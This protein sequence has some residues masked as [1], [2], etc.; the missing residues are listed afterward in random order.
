MMKRWLAG[1]MVLTMMTAGGTALAA[2]HHG[3]GAGRSNWTNA[4][5]TTTVSGVQ[6]LGYHRNCTNYVD[7][8]GDGVCD[9]WGSCPGYVDAD[10][11]SVCDN[12]GACVSYVDANGDGVCDTCGRMCG[13]NYVDADGDGVCDNW[14][15]RPNYVDANG[16][17]VC[18]NWSQSGYRQGCRGGHCG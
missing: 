13:G 8:N 14:G 1:A 18:D 15:T 4:S 3:R 17:G 5:S 16:D 10:G 6:T 11:N 9:T 2:G 12:R 7:A